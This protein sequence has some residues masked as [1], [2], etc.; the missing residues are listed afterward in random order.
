[1]PVAHTHTHTHVL[2]N[3]H[4]MAVGINAYHHSGTLIRGHR[5]PT[6]H[7]PASSSP[8]EAQVCTS[9]PHSKYKHRLGH[10]DDM[11]VEHE[12][13]TI[14]RVHIYMRASAPHAHVCLLTILT[15]YNNITTRVTY[16][17]QAHLHIR[18]IHGG[19]VTYHVPHPSIL[20]TWGIVLGQ[21]R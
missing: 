10:F 17:H 20:A 8:Y 7:L 13:T 1:M 21:T 12:R 2:G 9:V 15:Q 16:H 19:H 3:C 18:H 14:L 6:Y 5:S 11:I 4:D